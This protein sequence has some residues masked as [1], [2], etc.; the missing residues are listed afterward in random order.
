MAKPQYPFGEGTSL[1]HQKNKDPES[2]MGSYENPQYIDKSVRGAAIAEGIQDIA[3]SAAGAL[4]KSEEDEEDKTTQEDPRYKQEGYE[5]R[6]DY[7]KAKKYMR[8]GGG[9][10]FSGSTDSRPAF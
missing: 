1:P 5:T 7:R 3:S 9:G 8:Q 10:G 2:S 4:T 6:K